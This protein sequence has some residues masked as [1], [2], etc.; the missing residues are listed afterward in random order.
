MEA[1]AA[2]FLKY[3]IFMQFSQSLFL[4]FSTLFPY[5]TKKMKMGLVCAPI[6]G[7]RQIAP[8]SPDAIYL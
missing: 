6:V 1:F 7:R 3:S 4:A 5:N 8:F 2:F